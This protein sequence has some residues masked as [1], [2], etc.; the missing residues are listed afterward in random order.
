VEAPASAAESGQLHDRV[1]HGDGSPRNHRSHETGF[2]GSLFFIDC[3]EM[4]N[5]D[6]R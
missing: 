6:V 5:V 1:G 4:S 2:L 3:S